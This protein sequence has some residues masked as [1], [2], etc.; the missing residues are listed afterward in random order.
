MS[1]LAQYTQD[2]TF[3]LLTERANTSG[4]GRFI[5][6]LSRRKGLSGAPESIATLAGATLAHVTSPE[7]WLPTL[8]GGGEVMM[9]VMH[10]STPTQR[11][12]GMLTFQFPGAP[13]VQPNAAMIGRG[14]WTGPT[15]L[16]YLGTA[17]QPL[18]SWAP[19]AQQA[20]QTQQQVQQH[21]TQQAGVTFVGGNGLPPQAPSEPGWLAEQRAALLRAEADLR[22]REQRIARAQSEKEAALARSE[23][24]QK[25]RAEFDQKM[26]EIELKQAA[27]NAQAV[28]P[29]DNTI[30]KIAALV[31]PLLSAWLT[32]SQ[33]TQAENARI[34]REAQERSDR[35]FEETM[36]L[37]TQKP[38][39]SEETRL[40]IET[41]RGAGSGNAE[42]MTRFVDAMSTVSKTSVSMIE[43]VADIRLGG[44]P[45]SPV[46]MAVREGISAMKALSSG[47]T[48]GARKVVTRPV[49]PQ[50]TQQ[51]LP[52]RAPTQPGAPAGAVPTGPQ[53]PVAAPGNSFNEAPPAPSAIDPDDDPV[54]ILESAVRSQRDPA[55]VAA[56]FLQALSHPK[57]KA[58]LVEHGNDPYLLLGK[59]LGDWA[60]APEN[61]QYIAALGAQ[62]D[63]QGKAAGVFAADDAGDDGVYEDDDDQDDGQVDAG[64]A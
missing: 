51:Q 20:Q 14:D 64:A 19:Q 58:A 37:I 35:R 42:M 25:L 39:M 47:A 10:Q 41:L 22:E 63:A 26:R 61:Q 3:Q 5:V 49:A 57:M 55:Q 18:P 4:D 2:E 17:M 45:E 11:V 9:H 50:V 33:A 31:T 62:L 15:E 16:V 30:E 56:Y 34:A 29:P 24:E 36:K 1:P 54:A 32:T 52:P 6:K 27:A 44:E 7:S 46:M 53:V 12:G 43:A 28:R 13:L 21:P 59:R 40:L 48:G 8:V 38:G 23:S 60:L